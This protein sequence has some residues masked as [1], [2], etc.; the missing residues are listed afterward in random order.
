MKGSVT[1]STGAP[2]NSS[3]LSLTSDLFSGLSC[4]GLQTLLF[5]WKGSPS[6]STIWFLRA[7]FLLLS[8]SFVGASL[9]AFRS[10]SIVVRAL[11]RGAAVWL[12]LLTY[13]FFA[14][15]LSWLTYGAATLAGLRWQPW[16]IV[17]VWFSI[18]ALAC[19][20]ASRS[21]VVG[22]RINSSV[23]MSE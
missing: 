15:C 20:E 5:F 9:L 13:L 12:A 11:Y 19:R 21:V 4:H 18:A 3:C 7:A 6:P 10:H 23:P 22:Q 8:I 16:H 1:G 2:P 17:L 14:S